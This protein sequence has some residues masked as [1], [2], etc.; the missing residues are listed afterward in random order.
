MSLQNIRQPA[1]KLRPVDLLHAGQL[2]IIK[3]HL[4]AQAAQIAKHKIQRLLIHTRPTA[5][6]KHQTQTKTLNKP[7]LLR[8]KAN[9]QAG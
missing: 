3:A 9:A 6:L 8:T 5:H 7:G 4:R 1:G 2:I